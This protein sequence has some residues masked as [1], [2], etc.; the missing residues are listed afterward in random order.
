MMKLLRAAACAVLLSLLTMPAALA[1]QGS[2]CMPTTGTV[3]G[4]AFAQDVNAGIAAL[5]SQ[6]SGASAPA[7][8]CTGVAIK[9]QLWLDTSVTPNL[10]KMYDG[11]SWVVFGGVN[12]TDHLWAPPVGGGM[13]TVT[14]ATTT[15]ICAS[16]A[17]VQTVSGTT[18]ITG[19]GSACAVGQI[20]KLIFSSAT[21]LTYDA[22]SLIIPGQRSYTTTAGDLAE[23]IYLGSGHWRI[24][25]ITKID[26]SSVVNPSVPLG[27]IVY[28]D[29]GTIPAKALIAAGQ[30]ISR[31]SYP[32]YLA[33][34]TRAQSGTLT[35]GNNTVTSVSNT[36]GLGFG[37]PIEGTG[38][39]S[40]TTITSVTSS[41]I[42]MS[43][44]A[45]ANG[46]QTVTAFITGYGSGGDSTTVGVRNCAGKVLAGRDNATGTA[47]NRLTSSFFGADATV[48]GNFGG[49]EKVTLSLPQLPVTTLT[50]TG[51]AGAL[52][53]D[54]TVSNIDQGRDNLSNITTGGGGTSLDGVH[55]DGS[56]HSTGTFTPSGTISSFGS[57]AA[58]AT[59]QPTSIEECVVFVLP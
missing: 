2:G 18:T 46:A 26:G 37:M 15:D 19:F 57:G 12:A 49:T 17:A 1:S 56:V 28:G 24:S 38:V 54:S 27:A 21:P 50:F 59:V 36:A 8:D 48:I 16:P 33:A 53:V 51:S 20:K 5:I 23:A 55:A 43:K 42:V 31:A 35:A 58:H 41:T 52:S 6:N 47:A 45:T 22:T 29:F 14:A 39:Q 7:T 30:A 40:G 44:T 10:L 25:N 34:V 11:A 4:L 9:G 13:V 32:D 3:S